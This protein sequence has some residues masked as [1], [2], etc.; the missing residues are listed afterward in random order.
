MARESRDEVRQRIDTLYDQAENATGNYNATRALSGGTRGRGVRLRRSDRGADPSLDSVARQW[1]DGARAK[2]GPS[3]PA[4]LPA[5]RTPRRPAER[6]PKVPEELL[7]RGLTAGALEAPAGRPLPELTAGTSGQTG[8]RAVPELTGRALPEL[9]GRP[10][11]ELTAGPVAALPSAPEPRRETPLALPAAAP[12]RSSPAVSKG[13]NQRKLAAARELLSR[14]TMRQAP[15]AA[16]AAIEPPRPAQDTWRGDADQTLQPAEQ[17]WLRQQWAGLSAGMSAAGTAV[18]AGDGT[19]AMAGAGTIPSPGPSTGTD[20]LTDTGALSAP[21]AAA[22]AGAMTGVVASPSADAMTATGA[23]AGM[24]TIPSPGRPIGMDTLTGTGTLAATGVMAGAGAMTG[25]GT[26][27]TTGAIAGMGTIPNAGT[28]IGTDTLTGTGTL[29]ATGVMAGAGAMTGAGA[30]PGVGMAT[31]AGMPPGAGAAVGVDPF[32]GAAAP[33]GATPVTGTGTFA[34]AAL[35]GDTGSFVGAGPLSDTGS[36]TGTGALTD[37][38]SLAQAGALTGTPSY[39][40]AGIAGSPAPADTGSFAVP[41]PATE[42]AYGGKGMKAVAFAR[43]QMGKPCVWGAT[44]PDSYDCSSLTQAAWKAA[45]VTLPR[46]AREQAG[47]GTPVALSEAQA[48]DLVFFFDDDNHVGLYV[49]SGMMVHAPGQGAYI[50]EESVYGA[51]ET[52]IHRVI[53]PA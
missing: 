7:G 34:A 13:Q 23:I 21:G 18:A 15:P 45:G 4:V 32:P 28:P 47:A 41:S 30:M 40:R 26:T 5:D 27:T 53:R 16:L 10:V 12:R 17:E 44:G 8:G 35:L 9:T 33:S 36:F 11:A 38:G 39:A 14:Q 3:V 1:M 19:G 42:P 2:L 22:G 25:T 29:A 37:T 52:A 51:G 49:G 20:A 24:G 46:A 48:G 50:R 43:A 6:R 31:G